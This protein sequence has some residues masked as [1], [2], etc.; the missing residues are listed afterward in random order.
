MPQTGREIE[1]LTRL[2]MLFLSAI[3]AHVLAGGTFVNAAHLTALITVI[4]LGLFLVR[5]AVLEGPPLALL[6]VLMQSIGH[7]VMGNGG[8][9]SDTQMTFSHLAA[10]ILSYFLIR[11][12]EKVW[13]QLRQLVRRLIPSF[14]FPSTQICPLGKALSVERFSAFSSIEFLASLRFRGPPLAREI[15]HAS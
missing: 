2:C 3:L 11:D 12:A 13:E 7:F 4:F 14:F 9:T 6:I 10:G 8:I 15:T 1:S 5:H